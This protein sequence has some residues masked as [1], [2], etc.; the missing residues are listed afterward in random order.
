MVSLSTISLPKEII[1]RILE[2]VPDIDIRRAFDIYRPFLEN[3]YTHLNTIIREPVHVESYHRFHFIRFRIPNWYDSDTRLS[4]NI[5][6]DHLDFE[7]WMNAD[8]VL[9]DVSIYHL[10]K[11]TAEYTGLERDQNYFKG[12]MDDYYWKSATFGYDSDWA[13]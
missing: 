11:K 9:Y 5:D 10:T 6:D 13:L 8:Q 3:R 7:L 2:Y 1:F 4:Q 12:T